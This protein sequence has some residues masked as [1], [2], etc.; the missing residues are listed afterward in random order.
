MFKKI[1]IVKEQQNVTLT[2]FYCLLYRQ[3]LFNVSRE[4]KKLSIVTKL[5]FDTVFIGPVST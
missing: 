5:G 4:D 1:W 3:I 2:M